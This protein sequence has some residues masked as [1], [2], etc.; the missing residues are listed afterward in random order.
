[1]ISKQSKILFLGLLF[2]V[3]LI[4]ARGGAPIAE[5][6][7]YKNLDRSGDCDTTLWGRVYNPDR[8]EIL[9]SC[10]TVTG[11]IE[12]SNPDDDGDQHMLLRL[13]KGF[14]NYVNERNFKK[15]NG[16]LV[17]EAVCVNGVYKKK[18]GSTCDGYVNNVLIPN[19]GDRVSVTGSFVNDTHNGWNEIH[20][21]T[22][23]EILK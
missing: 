18:V 22:K 13:D 2:I 23:I 3:A 15:K 20:P 5:N 14:E 8:L 12:E 17:I 19:I 7:E 9:N 16:C 21:I 6:N 10:V 4:F 1:M 11:T